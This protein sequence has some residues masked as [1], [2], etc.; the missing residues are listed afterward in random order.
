MV[1]HLTSTVNMNK[2]LLFVLL[3]AVA[4]FSVDRLVSHVY[5]PQKD[6]NK[7]IIYSTSW[8]PYCKA[9]RDTLDQY[10]IP[11]TEYD[12]EKSLHGMLGFWALR[13]RAVPVSVIGGQV[14]HGYDGQ[15]ITDAL[16]A[17]GYEIPPQWSDE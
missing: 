6:S 13:G 12:T 17:A 9:L 5:L 3:F 11:Y 7:V 4:I 2:P 10:H 1:K 14:I 16:A 8:C 15:T